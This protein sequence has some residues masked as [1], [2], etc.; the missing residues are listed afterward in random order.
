MPPPYTVAQLA[1]DLVSVLDDRGIPSASV[2]GYSQGG[3]VAQQ[4]AL[5]HPE[6]CARLVLACTYAFNVATIREKIEGRLVPLLIRVLGMRRFARLVVSQGL[7]RVD[8]ERAQWVVD[9]IADQ[10][11]GLMITA[12]KEA[13][14]FDSRSRLSEIT[15]PTLIVA[16]SN[17]NAVPFHHAEMLRMG[18]AGAQLVVIQDADHALV[19]AKPEELLRAV[20]D[21]LLA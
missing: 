21:F 5:D 19:W 20:A 1:S 11:P 8:K 2:L 6:R 12:W 3:A 13:M 15:C 16:G 14:A 10:D 4:F 7:S 9:L 17:D 18:I